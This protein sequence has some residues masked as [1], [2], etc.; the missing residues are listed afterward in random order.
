MLYRPYSINL[1]THSTNQCILHR[2]V[3]ASKYV[4]FTCSVFSLRLCFDG[5]ISSIIVSFLSQTTSKA[6]HVAETSHAVL[7]VKEL[8]NIVLVSSGTLIE[9]I[10]LLGV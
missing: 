2:H 8:R 1:C 6:V 7:N 9:C 5:Q 4:T 10:L 3:I